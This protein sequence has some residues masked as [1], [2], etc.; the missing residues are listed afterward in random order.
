METI[1][2]RAPKH[3]NNTASSNDVV[4]NS[5]LD[6]AYQYTAIGW[7]VLPIT[8]KDKIP[9]GGMGLTH[10]TKEA[11]VID[12]WWGKK[13]PDGSIAVLTGLESGIIVLDVDLKTGGYE[14]LKDLPPIPNTLTANTGGGGKHFV[15]Q[16]PGFHI[17]NSTS[18]IGGGLDI[19]GDGAYI[20]VAP[21]IHASGKEYQWENWGTPVAPSPGWLL[22]KIKAAATHKKSSKPGKELAIA[23]GSRNDTLFREACSMRARGLSEATITASIEALNKEQCDPPLPPE[24]LRQIVANACKYEPDANQAV[25][26]GGNTYSATDVGNAKLLIKRHGENLRYCPERK[27]WFVW[28]DKVWQEDTTREIDRRFIDTMENLTPDDFF[29]QLPST[30]DMKDFS[31]HRKQSLN[32]GKISAGTEVASI[33]EETLIANDK[34]DQHPNSLNLS[35]GTLDL[36]TGTLRPHTKEDFLTKILSYEYDEKAACPRFEQFMDDIMLGNQD[37]FTAL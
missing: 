18:K 13:W 19:K 32:R 17:G 5:P 4:V 35:N 8:P 14:S 26:I 30:Q 23:E 27:S 1:T 20:V 33:L 15:F 28:N 16:H 22:D 31:R 3:N 6:W 12:E 36:E 37:S 21:S 11:S 29:E 2:K 34:L 25:V 10:A 24:E 9:L 7:N